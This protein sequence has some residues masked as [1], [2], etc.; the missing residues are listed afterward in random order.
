V[1]DRILKQPNADHRAFVELL[2]LASDAGLDQTGL[3]FHA[4]E[5]QG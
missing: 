5:Q 4:G 2:L 3:A 1:R